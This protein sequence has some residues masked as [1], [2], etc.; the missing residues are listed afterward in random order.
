[1]TSV[2]TWNDACNRRQRANSTVRRSLSGRLR[3][4]VSWCRRVDCSETPP[5]LQLS[6]TPWWST[7]NPRS[8]QSAVPEAV[9]WAVAGWVELRQNHRL[10]V[11][12]VV[13]S[14]WWETCCSWVCGDWLAAPL[15]PAA[16]TYRYR[17]VT[18]QPCSSHSTQFNSSSSL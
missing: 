14:V 9:V 10:L 15:D 8:R 11:V 17:D 12:V 1:M 13:V 5:C 2:K 7:P 18:Q 3:F 6:P 16:V 4:L